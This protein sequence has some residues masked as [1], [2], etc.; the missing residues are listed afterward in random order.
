MS[1]ERAYLICLLFFVMQIIEYKFKITKFCDSKFKIIFLVER[2]HRKS[3]EK[4][5]VSGIV[6]RSSPLKLI[7]NSL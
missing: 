1:L 2:L 4:R 6:S 7:Y 3:S 5:H